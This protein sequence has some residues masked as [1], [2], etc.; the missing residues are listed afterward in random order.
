M[1]EYDRRA[2]VFSQEKLG[3]AVA[4]HD[5]DE[6]FMGED[7]LKL[8]VAAGIRRDTGIAAPVKC[9]QPV[10]PRQIEAEHRENIPVNG[11]VIPAEPSSARVI[12]RIEETEG[13]ED[14]ISAGIGEPS[15]R[16]VVT[17]NSP[18]PSILSIPWAVIW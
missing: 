2:V 1:G 11:D 13:G 15:R 14:N 12:R 5:G 6:R 4:A 7:F 9:E 3:M 16:N 8:T 18:G 17:V 10:M